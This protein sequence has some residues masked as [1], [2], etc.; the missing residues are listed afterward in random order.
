M[1]WGSHTHKKYSKP[2]SECTML[3]L[4]VRFNRDEIKGKIVNRE[5]IHV[6]KEPRRFQANISSEIR[7]WT[8]RDDPVPNTQRA[9]SVRRSSFCNTRNVDSL[10]EE[11]LNAEDQSE[12]HLKKHNCLARNVCQV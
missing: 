6:M 7:M 4:L 11:R 12:S 3:E 8:Y 9:V 10:E 5:W 1:I 2:T